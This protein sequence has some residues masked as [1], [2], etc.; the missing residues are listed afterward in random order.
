MGKILDMTGSLVGITTA[1]GQPITDLKAANL[2]AQTSAMAANV[3][4]GL[5]SVV[6]RNPALAA[7][8]AGADFA[9]LRYSIEVAI[10]DYKAFNGTGAAWTLAQKKEFVGDVFEAVGDASAGLG[11][12]LGQSPTSGVKK[13]ALGAEAVGDGMTISGILLEA[14]DAA[15][16]IWDKLQSTI[17]DELNGAYVDFAASPGFQ[18]QTSVNAWTSPDSTFLATV[19]DMT[20]LL[21]DYGSPAF[22][23]AAATVGKDLT[24]TGV[25]LSDYYDTTGLP[26]ED[27]KI[28]QSGDNVTLT[29][30]D[31][32]V[33][34]IIGNVSVSPDAVAGV[35]TATTTVNGTPITVVEQ[36]DNSSVVKTVDQ[37]GNPVQTD[38]LPDGGSVVITTDADGTTNYVGYTGTDGT[39]AMTFFGQQYGDQTTSVSFFDPNTGAEIYSAYYDKNGK[40][41]GETVKQDTSSS[42]DFN[43]NS[44]LNTIAVTAA[45]AVIGALLPNDA[46]AR[47]VSEAAASTTIGTVLGT[48]NSFKIRYTTYTGTSALAANFGLALSSDVIELVDGEFAADLNKLLNLPLPVGSITVDAA[49]TVAAQLLTAEV[50]KDVV[51]VTE[52]LGV[53]TTAAGTSISINI[54]DAFEGGVISGLGLAAGQALG[55]LVVP[56]TTATQITSSLFG[57]IGTGIVLYFAPEL[58]PLEILG[59]SAITSFVGDLIGAIFGD[60]YRGRAFSDGPIQLQNGRLV[61]GIVTVDNGGV[62]GL[63]ASLQK[64]VINYD[65]PLLASFGGRVTSMSYG[66]WEISKV[67]TSSSDQAFGRRPP[68]RKL[69]IRTTP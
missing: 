45:N 34:P 68:V 38:N 26:P 40:L 48:A 1:S 58:A 23:A 10:Q 11:A 47:I 16:V 20:G 31:P 22:S 51:G 59:V 69:A 28:S 39:G 8:A 56:Q 36:S 9:A 64:S 4:A 43:Y 61:A 62:A 32:D 18:T 57:T 5:P 13:F 2:V 50:A 21:N 65:N 7:E 46:A 27:I 6:S 19:K 66:P 12:M 29:S 14:P 33:P 52:G 54:G 25:A 15:G 44:Y 3:L 41:L 35:A 53:T 67:I 37:N 49:N 17:S 24:N 60:G 63:V 42:P 55:S 30:S